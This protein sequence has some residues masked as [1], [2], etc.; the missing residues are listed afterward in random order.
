MDP[1]LLASLGMAVMFVLIIL[2]VPIGIAMIVVGVGGFFILSGHGPALSLLAVE[3]AGVMSNSDLAVIPLFLLM[4]SFATVSGLS[5]DIY[6]LAYAYIGHLRGGL[7]LAT[8]G[9]CALFG[10]ICGSSPATA[11]TFGRVA[12]PEMLRRGYSK[13]FATGTIAAGGTLGSMVPPSVIMVIYAVIAEVFILDLFVAAVV[14]AILAVVLHLTVINIYVRLAPG[15]APAGQKSSWD[16]RLLATRKSWGVVVLIGTVFGGIYGGV[17]TVNEAA[18]VGAGMAFLF[19]L[20]GGNMT[21][22][23]FWKT[24]METAANTAMIY[25]IIFGAQI[26]IYFLTLTHAPTAMVAAI[27]SLHLPP[28]AVLLVLLIIYIILGSIFDTVSALVI[29]TPFVLPLILSM[30]YDPVWWG[31]VM[32]VVVELGMITPPIGINVFVLQGIA[33]DIPLGT[34]FRGVT[35]FVISD[36]IRLAL[37]TLFP[38]LVLW[39]PSFVRGL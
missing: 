2:H 12:L 11:A 28:L 20:F 3:P 8:I 14:P 13:S 26:F 7:A 34:I 19:A 23:T 22:E 9:G 31:I 4:G 25:L 1:I 33:K 16:E 18:A 21:W 39:W 17:F 27:N 29:T 15:A 24:L 30:G 36:T 38:A 10:A 5:A 35:P 37:L 32:V 6:R